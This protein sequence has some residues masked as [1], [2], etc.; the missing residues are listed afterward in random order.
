MKLLLGVGVGL[1]L[2]VLL[3]AL[4]RGRRTRSESREVSQSE[5]DR[6]TGEGG[7]P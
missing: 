4:V 7:I 5:L 2:G 3:G 1:T 6:M